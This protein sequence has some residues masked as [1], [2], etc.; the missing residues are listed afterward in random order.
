MQEIDVN[1]MS[2][3]VWAYMGDSVY[4]QY[5]RNYLVTNT[6]YKP[7]KL[8]IEATKFVKA[9]AQAEILKKLEDILTEEEK[10]I[11][12][13]TRNTENH[14]VAKNASVQDYMYATAFE[15]LVGYLYL[16][17]QLERLKNSII[18]WNEM[19]AK[20]IYMNF[21]YLYYYLYI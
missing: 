5:I 13:R 17:K 21:Y 2:P 19:W 3:L 7:H 15:G 9:S 14:H 18:K 20:P 6:K 1:Q 11:V 8:H 12:R 10:D 4:E 16:T